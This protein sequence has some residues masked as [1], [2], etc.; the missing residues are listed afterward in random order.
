M[1]SGI[2]IFVL[3]IILIFKIFYDIATVK[4]G[5]VTGALL[6]IIILFALLFFLSVG[7]IFAFLLNYMKKELESTESITSI[8][9]T[10]ELFDFAEKD[11]HPTE[12]AWREPS[13]VNQE[14]SCQMNKK[15]TKTKTTK[16]ISR[17]RS[18]DKGISSGGL[19]N[20]LTSILTKNEKLKNEGKMEKEEKKTA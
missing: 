9:E 16:T 19:L 20:N 8:I 2:I 1:I 3:I 14:N 15:P 18:R 6:R 11:L 12:N 7:A 5:E 10:T 13:N 17:S 4:T